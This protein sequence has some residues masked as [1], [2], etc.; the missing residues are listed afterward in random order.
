MGTHTS[1]SV[2][3]AQASIEHDLIPLSK[4]KNCEIMRIAINTVDAVGH[5]N[6]VITLA[7]KLMER[8]HFVRFYLP[9]AKYEDSIRALPFVNMDI[10]EVYLD[11]SMLNVELV[12]Y[13]E[14]HES[15]Q[16]VNDHVQ[17]IVSR[18]YHNMPRYLEELRRFGPD[19]IVYD[20]FLI[21][22]PI[23][24]HLL[25][26]PCCGTITFPGFNYFHMLYGHHT[27]ECMRHAIEEYK[28]S[29]TL[30][31]Y[32]DLYLERY[33]F[34]IFKNFVLLNNSLPKGLNIC[35]GIKEFELKMP[36]VV[37]EVYGEMDKDCVYVGPMLLSE[38]EGRVNSSPI[39]HLSQEHQWIDDPFPYDD[40]Q[41]SKRKGKQIIYVSF[42][43][44]ATNM[45]WDKYTAPS[46]M[47]GAV[48]SGKEFCRNLWQKIFKAFGWKDKYVVVMATVAE[49]PNALEG[50]EVPSNFIVRRRCPQ[51]EILKVADAF[52]THGGANSMTESI[53]SR[54]PMLVLPF[55]A[56]QYDNARTVSREHL[57]LHYDDPLSSTSRFIF[58]DVK[59]LLMMRE[60]YGSNCGR[61]EEQLRKAGGA[62][63]ASEAIET[64]VANF[65]GHQLTKSLSK[66][67][68]VDFLD[69]LI[70]RCNTQTYR[71]HECGPSFDNMLPSEVYN[72]E[73]SRSLAKISSFNA[74]KSF[75]VED[76]DY[77]W[78]RWNS[79]RSLSGRSLS[80][81]FR[82]L[83][84][85]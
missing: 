69:F 11:E 20:P 58:N 27:Q 64:Y 53:H 50:L 70:Q 32:R 66:S 26:V 23:A 35:T 55:F 57:G 81:S 85:N 67:F 4:S 79:G 18:S 7:S 54:V 29:K 42:G 59:T 71:P 45:F 31:T 9:S 41:E 39:A 83:D 15:D 46:K 36:N 47:F 63:K 60:H 6:P 82:E 16:K 13:G 51:L 61:L 75:D 62:E 38:E 21:N 12:S 8:G 17:S 28:Q 5:L 77:Y 44:V 10:C 24:A 68:D 43:T 34:D 52:I 72:R 2:D 73:R 30:V 22:P 80:G 65:Q 40:L 76:V 19:L 74:G 14:E 78:Q 48:V 49:D 56:D 1:A 37:K 3:V 33:G 25:N 84:C